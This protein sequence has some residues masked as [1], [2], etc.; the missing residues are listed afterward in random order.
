MS[1]IDPPPQLTHADVLTAAE[2][3][4]L[5]QMPVSTVYYLARRGVLPARRF[6]RTWRFFRPSREQ[7]PRAE[8]PR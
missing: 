2:V 3:A 5:L 1:T 8:P 4:S 6:G 7:L